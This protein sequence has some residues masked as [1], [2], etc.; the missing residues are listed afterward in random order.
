MGG[1]EEELTN[2]LDSALFASG[3]ATELA[4]SLLQT[5]TQPS[6]ETMAIFCCSSHRYETLN[7]DDGWIDSP[8]RER[9]GPSLPGGPLMLQ[10]SLTR[11]AK[12]H[13]AQHLS[14]LKEPFFATDKRR[15]D[16]LLGA[17]RHEGRN[18]EW[19]ERSGSVAQ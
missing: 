15:T 19:T 10:L 3:A 2:V 14:P 9:E 13:A 7:D 8:M 11:G 12:L 17:T 4:M 16:A 6:R 18:A 5:T 1:R